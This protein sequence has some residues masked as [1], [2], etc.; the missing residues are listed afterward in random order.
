M[1]LNISKILA[2]VCICWYNASLSIWLIILLM[3]IQ[4]GSRYLWIICPKIQ[5]FVQKVADIR[6]ID[7]LVFRVVVQ[8][9]NDSRT[10]WGGAISL[11]LGLS[12]SRIGRE[13]I[14][15]GSIGVHRMKMNTHA[16]LLN[17]RVNNYL[18]MFT[19]NLW[20]ETCMYKLLSQQS[21][22]R[23]N[24]ADPGSTS[25]ATFQCMQFFFCCFYRFPFYF[26][27]I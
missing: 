18:C 4:K 11:L 15:H 7:K 26:I 1:S 14:M 24:V 20:G 19:A 16:V 6:D 5:W 9:G 23:K 12:L 21:T 25:W 2:I 17:K 27:F 10:W 3:L 22:T 13:Q 8:Q